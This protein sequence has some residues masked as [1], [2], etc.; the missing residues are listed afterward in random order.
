LGRRDRNT[1]HS[2]RGSSSWSPHPLPSQPLRVRAQ[3]PLS[4]G[5]GVPK[6]S[7]GWWPIECQCLDIPRSIQVFA[8]KGIRQRPVPGGTTPET[9][10]HACRVPLG[11]LKWMPGG[12]AKQKW[13]HG[14]KRVRRKRL[15][16]E[17]AQSSTSCQRRNVLGSAFPPA[18]G[19][20]CPTSSG[21]AQSRKGEEGVVQA[22]RPPAGQGGSR[23][24]SQGYCIGE[25]LRGL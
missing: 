12:P 5:A 3:F 2:R 20:C 1:T 7:I 21:L 23:T 6:S 4:D 14:R 18:G 15:V 24:R 19:G 10:V 25:E 9:P 17:T 13:G 8:N 11:G 22:L 16:R